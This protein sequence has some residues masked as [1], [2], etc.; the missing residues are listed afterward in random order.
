MSER[1]FGEKTSNAPSPCGKMIYTMAQSYFKIV[2]PLQ[3]NCYMGIKKNK[4]FKNLVRH[5]GP[6]WPASFYMIEFDPL[7]PGITCFPQWRHNK[8]AKVGKKLT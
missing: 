8:S 6:V 4:K 5:S 3:A 7:K 1:L 2:Q